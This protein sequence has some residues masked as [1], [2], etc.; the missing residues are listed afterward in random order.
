MVAL[1]GKVHREISARAQ[2]DIDEGINYESAITTVPSSGEIRK[3]PSVDLC[4]KSGRKV[5]KSCLA[6][7]EAT[8][9]SVLRH[10]LVRSEIS[11][12][13]VLPEYIEACSLSGKRAVRD[14]LAVSDV[15][16]KSVAKIFF[17]NLKSLALFFCPKAER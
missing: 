14:E 9:A 1:G 10:Y 15:S 6:R 4:V 12:R 2:F 17:K 11:G 5:P 16:R 7:C 3:I 13:E 8:G